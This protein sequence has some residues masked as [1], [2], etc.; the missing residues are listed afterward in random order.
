MGLTK[1][2]QQHA[3]QL[4]FTKLTRDTKAEENRYQAQSTSRYLKIWRFKKRPLLEGSFESKFP[5][6][7]TS[8]RIF[9]FKSDVA[10]L[11][12]IAHIYL[13]RIISV[14]KFSKIKDL[15]WLKKRLSHHPCPASKRDMSYGVW[16]IY[17]NNISYRDHSNQLNPSVSYLRGTLLW[18]II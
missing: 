12:K 3:L 8:K 15:F 14:P 11:K 5:N 1:I 10:K 6:F 7:S 18:G 16:K 17:T 9:L 2:Y 13:S 4:H